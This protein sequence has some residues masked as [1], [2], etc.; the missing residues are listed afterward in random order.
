MRRE[1]LVL[2]AALMLSAGAGVG[3][4]A[5]ADI[6]CD[7][8]R[9]PEGCGGTT[10]IAPRL[11]T[12]INRSFRPATSKLPWMGTSV[13]LANVLNANAGDKR[14]PIGFSKEDVENGLDMAKPRLEKQGITVQ[15]NLFGMISISSSPSRKP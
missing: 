15:Q 4:S 8:V 6:Q 11:A 12:A 13:D 5:V 3:D 9:H 10:T 2:I 7:P 1:C 14:R